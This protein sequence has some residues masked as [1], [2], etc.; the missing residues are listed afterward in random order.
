MPVLEESLSRRLDA[1]S[2]DIAAAAD[3]A[4]RQRTVPAGLIDSMKEAGLFRIW[5]PKEIGGE[6][7]G[8]TDMA[9]LAEAIS[10]L[11]GSIGWTFTIGSTG[12]AFAG[13]LPPARVRE[14]FE[15]PGAVVAGSV[16]PRGEAAVVDGGYRVSGHWPLASGC[17][18]TT[19]LIANSRIT[20]NGA[21][22]MLPN[23]MPD[24]RGVLIP[25]SACQ[26]IDTWNSPGL[27]GTGSHDFRTED[28]F[29]PADRS[30]A[31][32]FA[33][34]LREE[35]LYQLPL[36]VLLAFPLGAVSLGIA[37]ASLDAFEALAA[38]G[39]TPSRGNVEIR[40]RASVQGDVGRA[41]AS[42]AAARAFYYEMADE[43]TD[44]AGRGPPLS[45]DIE[46]RRLLAATKAVD[47][48]REVTS[49][50]FL[51]G[52]SS[53]VLAPN[54]LERC[55]RDAH[56]VAQHFGVAP[57]NWETAGRHFLKVPMAQM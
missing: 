19:W 9:L 48:A 1:L 46:A 37:R 51:L 41:E 33:P 45:D 11:D 26:I 53:S 34:P 57:M 22:R 13:H 50:M 49:S 25:T 43:L 52:G 21:P 3:E 2:S 44:A 5:L 40:S 10:R 42:L 12:A 7:L 16:V 30:V 23:G 15:D 39:R 17:M 4:D 38:G 56:A 27:R 8:L 18:H 55:F 29:V 14:V 24:M 35:P 6:M 36:P 31:F 32:G 47:V 28:Q 54:A 20:E